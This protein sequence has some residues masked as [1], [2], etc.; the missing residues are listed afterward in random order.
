MARPVQPDPA[1]RRPSATAHARE[2][3]RLTMRTMTTTTATTTIVRSH[4]IPV[5]MESAA[6]GL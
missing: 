4:V 1:S 2:P 3:M 5:A 6:P